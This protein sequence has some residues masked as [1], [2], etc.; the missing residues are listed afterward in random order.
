MNGKQEINNTAKGLWL[1][2]DQAAS[3]LSLKPDTVKKKCRAGEFTFKVTK[4]D[5]RIIYNILLSALP[6][7][8][9]NKFLNIPNVKINTQEYSNAPEWAKKQAEKYVTIIQ[10]TEWLKGS[11]LRDFI[12]EWN[13]VNPELK[14]SYAA[15]NNARIKYKCEGISALLAQYGKTAGNSKVNNKY[16]EYFKN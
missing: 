10:Q 16:F 8:V 13:I 7:E 11:E 6:E 14:T 15:V 4:K 9:Q 3:L 2:E 1:D 5:G 12:K